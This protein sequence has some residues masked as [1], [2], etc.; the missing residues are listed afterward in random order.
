MVLLKNDDKILPLKKGQ[1]IAVIG[2]MAKS[3]RFQGAGSSVINP[4]K[5]DNAY[6]ELVKLGADVTYAQGYYKSAPGKR[7]KTESRMLSLFRKLLQLQ[8]QLMLPLF[9]LVL[10]RNLRVRATTEKI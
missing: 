5:L 2:E 6:D 4:T 3:P 9:S 1:K 8:R 7:I 10:P